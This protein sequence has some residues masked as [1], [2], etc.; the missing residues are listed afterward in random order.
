ML[1][2]VATMTSLLLAACTTSSAG[3]VVDAAAPVD[4]AFDVSPAD[5]GDGG[6]ADARPSQE[7]GVQGGA[8]VVRP[9][10]SACVQDAGVCCISPN[11][12]PPPVPEYVVSCA[13][14]DPDAGAGYDTL[15]C[16]DENDCSGGDVCCAASTA[17]GGVTSVCAPSCDPAQRQ[18]ELC[19]SNAPSTKCPASA[20]C[21]KASIDAW[22][23]PHC[24]GTCG[25]V[26]PP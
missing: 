15:A 18:V 25:G 16:N 21:S 14:C 2:R 22:H 7:G 6:T 3:T 9:A 4:A 13:A 23:L 24:Y 11:P 26:A 20:P 19:N 1:A 17:S 8:C 10:C 5:A 12:A